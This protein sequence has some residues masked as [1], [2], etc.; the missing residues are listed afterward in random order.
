MCGERERAR[1]VG[2]VRWDKSMETV[3]WQTKRIFFLFGLS[4]LVRG[5]FGV[6]HATR[7]EGM[8]WDSEGEAA[9]WGSCC[10]A[11]GWRGIS[12]GVFDA[13]GVHLNQ[14]VGEGVEGVEEEEVGVACAVA[15][16]CFE[17][18]GLGTRKGLHLDGVGGR[19][20]LATFGG[21]VGEHA[22]AEWGVVGAGQQDGVEADGDEALRTEARCTEGQG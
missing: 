19:V 14:A 17:E 11:E 13:G 6:I 1:M 8:L 2:M 5:E 10:E 9:R 20:A 12:A 18:G 15:E 4:G 7:K 22:C 16:E 21:A 3:P